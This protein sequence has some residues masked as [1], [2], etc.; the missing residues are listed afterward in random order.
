MTKVIAANGNLIPE[1][2]RPIVFVNRYDVS[3]KIWKETLYKPRD[4]YRIVYLG[5][6]DDNFDYFAAYIDSDNAFELFQGFLNDA[7]VK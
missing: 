4:C 6:K 3:H 5:K 7:V 2:P 1:N